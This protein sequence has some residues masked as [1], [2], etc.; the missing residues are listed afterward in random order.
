MPGPTEVQQARRDNGP[1]TDRGA[2]RKRALLDAARR[3]FERKGFIE[4]RVTDV[5]KEAQVSHGTFYTY[6]DT[7][8][9][10]FSAVA[11]DMVD[12]MLAAMSTPIPTTGFDERIHDLVRRF[13]QAYRPHATMIGLIEQVGTFSPEMRELRLD[14]R[15]TFV[16][17]T[18][19]GIQRLR[20]GG[21]LTDPDMDVEYTAEVLGAMLEYTC[22]LWF[23]LDK[24]FDEDRL[25]DT[26]A[27]VWR[28][29]L[30]AAR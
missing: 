12:A 29:T 7:K 9:A 2:T 28:K 4:T 24:N 10:I 19:R 1:L 8:E 21:V 17:R 23:C 18:K 25:V 14:I 27:F 5:V 11:H 16:K 20:A 30:R 13:V 3:V 22:Y 6:F 15:D 26:L